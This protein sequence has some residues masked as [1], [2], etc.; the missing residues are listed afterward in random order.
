MHAYCPCRTARI[1][2]RADP[3][4]QPGPDR[5]SRA[6]PARYRSRTRA[7][8]AAGPASWALHDT[9]CDG[10]PP[11]G[12]GEG[13]RRRTAAVPGPA[14]RRPAFSRL[15]VG[16]A[17]RS[18]AEAAPTRN[19]RR[20]RPLPLSTPTT[21]ARPALPFPFSSL[22]SLP[23]AGCGGVLRGMSGTA[24]SRKRP[25]ELQTCGRMPGEGEQMP[26]GMWEGF[27]AGVPSRSQAGLPLCEPVRPGGRQNS[28]GCRPAC[29]YGKADVITAD[30]ASGNRPGRAQHRIAQQPGRRIR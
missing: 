10:R 27:T 16:P 8:T 19:R 14:P 5:P 25:G 9:L 28:S 13:R 26:A 2:H 17:R 3:L 30:T 29:P 11:R 21:P 15:R 23:G 18:S 12:S 6:L 1:R 4:P 7:R 24:T 20:R 22:L